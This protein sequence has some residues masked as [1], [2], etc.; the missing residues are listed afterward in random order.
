MYPGMS[1]TLLDFATQ[2]QAGGKPQTLYAYA[3]DRMG[4]RASK[5]L[6]NKNHQ[7]DIASSVA[8]GN[9]ACLPAQ[10]SVSMKNTSPCFTCLPTYRFETVLASKS[11]AAHWPTVIRTRVS[12][13]KH[14][15]VSSA[16]T[17]AEHGPLPGVSEFSERG[18]HV[19][20]TGDA[21]L[22][23]PATAGS[24]GRT[25]AGDGMSRAVSP[26]SPTGVSPGRDTPPWSCQLTGAEMWKSVCSWGLRNIH[27]GV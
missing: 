20:M 21:M 27:P 4:W 23:W 24:A 18:R 9:T 3:C 10:L 11:P 1:P 22:R 8:C 16:V 7:L 26:V 17:A 14:A 19:A 12:G 5:R 13:V 15:V 6:N 2:A 25:G